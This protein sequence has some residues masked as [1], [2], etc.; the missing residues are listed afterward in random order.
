MEP[1]AASE[2]GITSGNLNCIPVHT[3]NRLGVYS[4][5]GYA[6]NALN[7]VCVPLT[8]IANN[9]RPSIKLCT[10]NVR[11]I[12]NKSADFIDY[13]C[14]SDADLFALTET[15]LADED[16]AHRAQMVPVGYKLIDRSRVDRVGGGTALL[17]RENINV[18]KIGSEERRSFEYLELLVSSGSFR[19][20]LVIVYRPPY[21]SSHP[22]TLNTFNSDFAEFVE[23]IILSTEP[24]VITGDFNIHVDD[25]SDTSAAQ[26]LDLLQS[27]GLEQHVDKPTHEHGHILDLV[28]TRQVDGIL[29]GLPVV[30]RMFSDHLS[31][32]STLNVP[33]PNTTVKERAYRKIKA[34]DIDS[35]TKDLEESDLCRDTPAEL[36]ELVHCYNTTLADLLD[37][38]APLQRKRVTVRPRVPWYNDDILAAKRMRRKAERKWRATKSVADLNNYKAKRNLATNL[39]NRAR[40]AYYK[41]LIDENSSDQKRLFKVAK[42]LMK[43]DTAV[44]FPPHSDPSVLANDFGNFFVEKITKIRDGFTECCDDCCQEPV[45]VTDSDQASLETFNVLSESDV[46]DIILASAKRT[47]AL[48]PFPTHLVIQC[49]DVLLPVLTSMV[50]LSLQNGEF[51]DNWKEALVLPIL[52]KIGLDLIFKNYRPVSNLPFVSKITERAVCLQTHDHLTLC[53]LYPSLQSAYRQNHST[54]TTLL[55]VRNDVLMKMNSQHAVLL[56]LLDLSAA[57]DTVDHTTLLR[58]LNCSFGVSGTAL[59]WFSSYLSGRSQRVSI[60]GALSRSF[61]LE[62]GVPQGSCLGPLLY[63]IYASRLFDIIESHL[64]DVHCYADDTQLYVSFKPDGST[65]QEDAMSAMQDCVRDIRTWMHHDKLLLNDDKTEFLILGTRQQLAKVNSS[66]LYIGNSSVKASRV[67]KN[68]GCWFDEK[69]TMNTHINKLCSAAFYHLHNIRSIRK[70][71]SRESA[72]TLVH[73]FVTSRLDYCNS[74]LYGLPSSQLAKV[75]RVQN[76]A[77]RVVCRLPKFCRI[78]PVLQE[79]HWLPIKFRIQFKI[80]VITF[81]A[82]HGMAPDYICNLISIKKKSRYNLRSEDTVRLDPPHCKLLS[83]IGDRAFVAAA[84]RLWNSLSADITNM[85]S[86]PTFKRQLKTFL[87]KCAF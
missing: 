68:L 67:V 12:K 56:V 43:Q 63:T 34:I 23:L 76:A 16:T 3:T 32:L 81:K 50:N 38:H 77:A 24:L 22:V 35:L 85:E 79:L 69:F 29:S 45:D 14:S 11:S 5:A 4:N 66:E 44:P 2:S 41:N 47:C 80:L 15:W 61:K 65:S 64:P 30:D 86:F 27:L 21:S 9:A 51:A 13:V 37:K 73:A 87:F 71:L 28:I 46:R 18:T 26:F 17:Y 36:A 57:F 1:P 84:P 53:G 33:K 52:K 72:E 54:E 39:M 83:T 58:R 49:L 6:V 74:L 19:V 60:P 75:Q 40:T 55:K 25:A 10:L 8:S 62:C 31:V 70:Y 78:T 48:D 7:L 59:R 82:I 20:R 42:Q